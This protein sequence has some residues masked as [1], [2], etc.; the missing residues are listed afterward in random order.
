M[1][2]FIGAFVVWCAG[3]VAVIAEPGPMAV[4]LMQAL[5][6]DSTLAVM[7]L[8]GLKYGQ[9]LGRDMLPDGGGPAWAAQVAALYDPE[10][11]AILV[12]HE[13]CAT[14][15]DGQA[16]PLIA[17]FSSDLGQKIIAGEL[18][19]RREFLD[20][21]TEEAAR[22]R[23]AGMDPTRDPRLAEISAYMAVND[24]VEYNVVGAMNSSYRFYSGLSRGGFLP[25]SEADI[26]ADT[27]AMEQAT[28]EDTEGWLLA[29][30]SEAYRDLTLDELRAYTELSASP[31]GQ[32]LNRA[33]FA[34]FDRLYE[35]LSLALGLALADVSRGED[36]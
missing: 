1:R 2:V 25:L 13:F 8:E 6:F 7:R 28:R 11:M 21:T 30:L 10:K 27:W 15:H 3:M 16:S 5:R 35:E 23:L 20:S 18:R 17:F 34:G 32:V 22:Q 9:E 4:R 36:I 12:S 24:L 26:V 14:L 31:E 19:A 29:Y 33:L